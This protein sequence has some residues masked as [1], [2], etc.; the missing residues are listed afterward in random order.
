VSE[1]VVHLLEVVDVEQHE[2]RG[3]AVA[4]A[5]LDLLLQRLEEE[6]A[7]VGAGERVAHRLLELL[8]VVARV[9]DGDRHLADEQAQQ[10][11]VALAQR[12]G[13][14]A[15]ERHHADLVAARGQREPGD[16]A[17]AADGGEQAVASGRLGPRVLGLPRT[18]GRA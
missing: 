16:L 2:R 9:L 11:Q 14:V 12:V 17:P 6:A 8:A 13:G 1:A 5:A 15:D 3:G 4:A 10:L 18:G 7:V